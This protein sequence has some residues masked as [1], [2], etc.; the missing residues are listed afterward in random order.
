MRLRLLGALGALGLT[1]ALLFA[2]SAAGAAGDA[3][4]RTYIVQM[5]LEPV[6][7]YD[8]GVAGI[9]ATAPEEGEKVD[10]DAAGVERYVDHLTRTHDQALAAVGGAE[11]VYDYVYSFNGVAAELT[12]AQAAAIQKAP[13]VLGVTEDT[14]HSVDTASTP[15]FLGLG[16]R[17]GLWRQLGGEGSAGEDIVI[18]VVDSGITPESPSFSDR[19]IKK[20]RRGDLVYGDVVYDAPDDWDGACQ[21]GESWGPGL[22]NNKL[23]G[24]RYFTGGWGG[25]AGLHAIRP[26]EFLSPR[27]FHGHGSHTT[28]TA[29]GNHGVRPT[30]AAA[31]FGQISGIA[32]RAR[33]A[34]YKALYSLEDASTANG[35]QTDFT[36][37]ID[38]AVADGVDVIN[39]SVGGTQTDFLNIVHEAFLNAAAAGIFVAT[40]AGNDG[41]AASSVAHPSPWVT[42]TA[43]TTHDRVGAGSVTIDGVEHG[44]AS[45]GTGSATGQLVTFGA[46]GSPERMCFAGTLTAAAAGKI[47]FCE[48]GVVARVEKSFEVQRVGGI[49]MVLVNAPAGGSLNADLHFVPTVHLQGDKYATIEAA[50]LAGK[51]AAIA[52]EVLEDQPAP[53]MAAFSSRGPILGGGGDLLKP[54]LGAP[55]VDV[56]AAV[57]PP[58]NRGRDF[59][60]YS[61]TS[62]AS[63]HV[64]GLAAL[65]MQLEP[66]WSPMAIKS[67]LMTTATDVLDEFAGTAAADAAATRAFAQGAG[68]VKPKSAA[69]PGLVYD[70][71]I[72]DWAAF[73]CGTNPG[74]FSQATC[75][76]LQGLGYS[77]DRSDMNLASIAIGDLAGTQTVKRRVT[78]VGDEASTYRAEVSLSGIDAVVAP[79]T[80]T[81]GPGETASFTIA[82]ARTTAPLNAYT[83]GSL[84][85]VEKGGNHTVRSPI[86]IKPVPMS[87]PA[88]VTS[89]GSPVSWEVKT[90]YAGTLAATVGGLV[91]ATTTPWTVAE[92]SDQDFDP[93]VAEGTFKYDVSVPGGSVLRA[94]ISEDAIMP[95]TGTDLD[96]YVYRGSALVAF[97]ADNDSDETATATNTSTAAT[98]SVYVHGFETNGPSAT[99]TLFTWVVGSTP[100][101]N[102]TLSG[103]GPAAVG[104][105]TH[106]ATFSGLA[107]ATRYLGRVDYSDGSAFLA[108]TLLAVRTP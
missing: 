106:T 45:A 56:L 13:G 78:N 96:L 17:N 82:F 23:I 21:E 53:F 20:D 87:A 26:W 7:T 97:S 81:I 4:T 102:V 6:L 47:V 42:T 79:S 104:T 46:A 80:L 39:F 107:P 11:K 37:A 59:D 91:P 18:G 101:G 25:D 73:L 32:P 94:A 98:Y 60:L 76:A 105:Q 22:C 90:G 24:A 16:A 55:G 41:P 95:A 93:A 67:A 83:G 66:D 58:G 43:A 92:D 77:L 84:T 65:L 3:A 15:K 9:P 62:M 19:Q 71:D 86:V 8:G 50:A 64:A 52:G 70:S 36:A 68:H 10:A 44:G 48:R 31:A 38:Q 5:Q 54:D 75:N 33:V 49:G 30:G 12:T 88:E 1:G 63:P 108:R 74:Y 28:S 61:G 34:M 89:D 99:G 29:G 14:L 35:W 2:V 85:W 103:V 51:T 69:D 72:Y 27:D 40:S 57:A 100:A